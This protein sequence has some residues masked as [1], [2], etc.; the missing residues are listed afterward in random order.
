MKGG[1]DL[2]IR[3]VRV[4]RKKKNRAPEALPENQSDETVESQPESLSDDESPLNQIYLNLSKAFHI[5]EYIFLAA[6]LIF[7]VT[8]VASNPKTIS[9]RNFIAILNEINAATPETDRYTKL[10][11]STETPEKSV[12]FGSGIA[13]LSED[14]IF[15]F[16][17]T[18]RFIYSQLHGIDEPYIAAK[19]KYAVVYGLGSNE[20]KIY[21]SYNQIHSGATEY[22]IYS[23]SV[24]DDGSVVFIEYLPNG[25]TRVCCYDASFEEIGYIDISGYAVDTDIAPDGNIHVLSVSASDGDGAVIFK[26]YDM[27]NGVT[28]AN[29]RF[30]G[31]WPIDIRALDNGYTALVFNNGTVMLDE[32]LNISENITHGKPVDVYFHGDLTAIA[33][34]EE[35]V[36]FDA[37]G[38]FRLRERLYDVPKSVCMSDNFVFLLADDHADR[39]SLSTDAKKESMAVPYDSCMIAALTDSH[40]VSFG[41]AG[42][43]MIDY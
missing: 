2:E 3:R 27:K 33:S 41:K 21:S 5:A 11:Y 1:R 26:S 24:S 15:M 43:A 30:D 10:G 29:H 9:Y 37:D 18:G 14:N 13:V 31:V 38:N 25:K 28:T 39:Y 6:T 23:C 32:D 34:A 20:Y 16:S 17:G 19:G 35:L 40:I 36:V 12:V 8:F 4:K 42:A 7:I 22:P